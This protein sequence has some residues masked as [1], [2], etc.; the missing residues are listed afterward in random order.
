MNASQ[1]GCRRVRY[2]P[3]NPDRLNQYFDSSVFSRAGI[4]TFGNSSRTS[5][6]LRAPSLRN[7][8]F[9]IFKNFQVREGMALRYQAEFYNGT[10]TPL[11]NSP[12]TTVNAVSGFGIITSANAQR[13][14]QMALKL[15]F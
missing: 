4:F 14:C 13:V 3:K 6:D 7:I 12:G 10:N 5:P 15:M 1:C 11:W 2:R 8:D 9:S